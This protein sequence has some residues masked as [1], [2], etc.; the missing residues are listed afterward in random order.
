MLSVPGGTALL[1]LGRRIRSLKSDERGSSRHTLTT[2]RYADRGVSRGVTAE[3]AVLL[4]EADVER[5]D[6]K[7]RAV[8]GLRR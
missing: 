6:L 5:L 7:E 2:P 3:V 8:V 1:G 4:D